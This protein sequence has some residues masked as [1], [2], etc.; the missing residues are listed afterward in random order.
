MAL[1]SLQREFV[2]GLL[3]EGTSASPLVRTRGPTDRVAVYRNNVFHNYREALQDIYPV[4]AKLV[5]D[6]FFQ[7]VARKFIPAYRSTSGNLGDYGAALPVFLKTLPEALGLPYLHDIARLEWAWHTA[8]HASRAPV[9]D[10]SRLAAVPPDQQSS[11]CLALNP[12]LQ[13]IASDYPILRIWEVN[14]N[15]FAGNEPVALEAGSDTLALM[16]EPDFSV[17]IERAGPG[18]YAFLS[19]CANGATVAEALGMAIEADGDFDLATA[20]RAYIDRGRLAAFSFSLA[21]SF[22]AATS[23]RGPASYIADTAV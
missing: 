2:Q 17:S 13:L 5:G 12:A 10:L 3:G 4:V 16:Q 11:V 14:Q 21:P 8:F 18:D 7:Y 23:D 19:A 15:D 20:L 1:R 22:N 6:D 9:L